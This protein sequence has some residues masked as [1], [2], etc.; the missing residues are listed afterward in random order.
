M[1][2]GRRREDKT[3]LPVGDQEAKWKEKRVILFGLC[4]VHFS[5]YIARDASLLRG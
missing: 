3:S 1:E 5:V 2:Y 4:S